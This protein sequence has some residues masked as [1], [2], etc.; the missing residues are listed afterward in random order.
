MRLLR[1]KTM[2]KWAIIFLVL[3]LIAGALGM[4]PVA[5]GARTISMVLF[6]IAV[7]MFVIFVIFILLGIMAVD[8][9]T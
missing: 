6:T 1:A 5:R 2:L 4:T 8:A 7:I 9:V 3:S